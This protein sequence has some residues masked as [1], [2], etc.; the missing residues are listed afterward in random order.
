M[1]ESLSSLAGPG[2]GHD[3]LELLVDDVVVV[4]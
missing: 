1:S 4:P 3:E 2:E